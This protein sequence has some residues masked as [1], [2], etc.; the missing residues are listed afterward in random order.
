MKGVWQRLLEAEGGEGSLQP[1]RTEDA[2][3]IQAPLGSRGAGG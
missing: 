1:P 2:C 3:G